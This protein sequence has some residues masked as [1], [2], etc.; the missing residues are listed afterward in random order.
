[1]FSGM[2]PKRG[3]FSIPVPKQQ[4][5]SED[6]LRNI[7]DNMMAP[8]MTPSLASA[9]LLSS[10][11]LQAINSQSNSHSVP[12]ASAPAPAA[13]LHDNESLAIPAKRGR[14]E[15][16]AKPLS[17]PP[18]ASSSSG[19]PSS[20]SGGVGVPMLAARKDAPR[21]AFSTRADP[22]LAAAATASDEAKAAALDEY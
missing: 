6:R 18:L 21:V 15:A 17:P 9:P 2:D 13:G 20:K 4:H 14:M 7:L 10:S 5:V 16:L 8:G 1:M 12:R 19:P 11:L 22:K 3:Q